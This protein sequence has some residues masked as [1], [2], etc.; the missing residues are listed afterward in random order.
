MSEHGASLPDLELKPFQCKYGSSVILHI[1]HLG[2]VSPPFKQEMQQIWRRFLHLMTLY[3][4]TF[5]I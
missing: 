5:V 3:F 4:I 1:S 2:S